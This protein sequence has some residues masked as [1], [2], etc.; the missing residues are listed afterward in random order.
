MNDQMYG[1]LLDAADIADDYE[2]VEFFPEFEGP[3]DWSD[4]PALLAETLRDALREEYSDASPVDLEDS[5]GN[6]LGSMS[7]GESFNF[8]KAL[9]QIETGAKQALSDPTV[10][11]IVRTALPVAGGAVGTIIGG[12]A[13]TALGSGLGNAAAS[14]LA[15]APTPAPAAAARP[16][17]IPQVAGG[18]AAAAQG[19]ILS[20]QPDVLKALLA[21]ALGQHGR[22]SVNGVPVAQIMNMLGSVFGQ[23]AADAD[24]L[25]YI[26]SEELDES[27]D[28]DGSDRSLYT[29]LMNAENAELAEMVGA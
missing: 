14:A 15:G 3:E 17:A 21:L 18:S 20:Q 19:L 6:V 11:Q 28:V 4:E 25:L 27:D 22:T 23:A 16:A 5:L 12:P 29:T 26:E 9:Q 2:D 8:A 24:E 7:P 13:G 1:H 10:G